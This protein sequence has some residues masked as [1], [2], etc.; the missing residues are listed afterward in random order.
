MKKV[1]INIISLI[2]LFLGNRFISNYNYYFSL[3]YCGIILFHIYY[4][5]SLIKEGLI[6]KSEAYY[7]IITSLLL[8]LITYFIICE[9]NPFSILLFYYTFNPLFVKSVLIIIIHMSFLRKYFNDIN[10]NLK[11]NIS[12]K[13]KYVFEFYLFHDFIKFIISNIPSKIVFIGIILFYILETFVFLNRI[14]LW[15]YFNN[16]NK[17]LPLLYKKNTTFYITSNVVNIENIIDS[18]IGEMKKLIN[19]LGKNNVIISLVENGDSKDNTRKYLEDFQ[20]Y[21]NE[22]KIMNKFYLSKEIED[23]R[24]NYFSKLMLTRLRIE[25]Y[26]KL[27]NKCLEFLYEIKN[28]D[29]DNTIVLFFNDI[30][31]GYE[32]IINLLST[33]N[34]D[35]DAVCGLDMVNNFFYDTWVSIDLD[36]NYLESKFPFFSNKEGQDLVTYHK[37]IRVFSCWNGVIAFKASPL[38]NKRIQF[39]HK[40][41]YSLPKYKINKQIKNYFESECTYLH[42]DMHSLGYS[43]KFINPD[44]KVTYYKKSLFEVNYLISLFCHYFS[45]FYYYFRSFLKKRNKYMSNY[46][47]ANIK[48]K[49]SLEEWYNENK[50]DIE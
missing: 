17:T 5:F 16:K 8:Y 33:N 6:S 13:K 4:F 27:R 18:Y 19:Y 2:I 47:E 44:V 15:V 25:Y 37:P 1:L 40:F 26:A 31:F 35:F 22:N 29:F 41:N 14:K 36:G 11:Q 23:P 12:F 20:E 32:N 21:L 9:P 7:F 38:K 49:P 48:L 45:Y 24:K 46:N 3:I 39:R 30:V 42:I 10:S 50:L 43:K 34:E 28:I